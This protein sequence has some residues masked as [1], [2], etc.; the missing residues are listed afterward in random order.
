M[1]MPKA[2]RSLALVRSQ[3]ALAVTFE[4]SAAAASQASPAR[5]IS[6]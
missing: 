6:C 2:V 5:R 1:S 3:S 4:I